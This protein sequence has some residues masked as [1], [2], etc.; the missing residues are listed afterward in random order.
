M[1]TSR[2]LNL[3]LNSAYGNI[4]NGNAL[5]DASVADTK[6]ATI[7]TAGKVSN[8][9]TTATDAN[10]N[11][12]IVARDGSGNFAATNVTASSLRSTAG[13]SVTVAALTG[14][15]V[16]T[17]YI[18][19]NTGTGITLNQLAA[20]G[21]VKTSAAGVLSTALIA[22]ADV[23]TNAAIA[24]TKLGTI[25]T[26]GKVSNSATTATNA[27]T[28]SA[29]VARDSSGN[30]IAGTLTLT[31][32][33]TTASGTLTL[34]AVNG[35]SATT[36]YVTINTTNGITLSQLA[37]A[38]LVHTNSSG[39]LSTSL[40]VDA[41]VASN[42]AIADTKLATISTSGKVSNTATTATSANTNSAIVARD[43]SGN[44]AANNITATTLSSVANASLSIAALNISSVSTTYVTVNTSSGITLNQLA[45]AGLVHTNASGVLSTS[46]L[47]NADVA[48]NAAIA[49]TKLGTISTSGKVSNSA[50]T[51]TN[52][53]TASAIVARDGSGNF[54][55]GTLTLTGVTTTTSGTLTLSAVNG[56]SATTNYVTINTTN[57]ITLPQLASAGLVHTNASGVL[58]TS[59]LVNADVATNAAIADTKLA[60]ISTSGKV[61]NS[62]TTAVSTNTA[63]AI[64]ARDG[65]GNFAAGNI[66]ATTLSSVANASLSIAALNVSSAST[67]YVTVNTASGITL[68][69]LAS[70]GL[71]HTNASGVL[72]TSLLVDADVASNAAIADTKLAT[73]S[74][75]GK[76]SNSATTASSSN[77]LNTIVARD[78]S[79]NTA[80]SEISANG[81]KSY[82]GSP[83]TFTALSGASAATMYISINTTDGITF[84]QHTTAGVLKTD[85][86]GIV[87]S[88]LLTNADVAAAAGIVDSKL[89][90]ISTAGKVSNSATTA[91][92]ANTASAIVARDANGD[93]TARNITTTG[94]VSFPSGGNTAL[95]TRY[96]EYSTTTGQVTGVNTHSNYTYHVTQ[97]GRVVTIT[98]SQLGGKT[99]TASSD[100]IINVPSQFRPTTQQYKQM[101]VISGSTVQTGRLSAS[102]TQISIQPTTNGGNWS[103]TSTS[104]GWHAT[105][106]SWV[107][108]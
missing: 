14:G 89:A 91:T 65:S 96:E 10:T 27:N 63:S 106:I 30:F 6:L 21:V 98:L 97:V 52:A 35:S 82:A 44:F 40:L 4:V 73:I 90:T 25:S 58:S 101:T 2:V 31:G 53:N 57:G 76:V 42:A 102:S 41:D 103:S 24:D 108:I 50:T 78:G 22:N 51:A 77:G 17:T 7:S 16:V 19:V 33:T 86:S 1:A 8:S 70:A 54:I 92:N 32:I 47:V 87:S 38:G 49:D 15:S 23:A 107:L 56:S 13:G 48:T 18:T 55:A 66:T 69:Q 68:N 12:A 5:V 34:S 67:T 59:L 94:G 88:S 104:S 43:G 83:L 105:S 74:T 84:P 79:G 11:S 81:L 61:S 20:A 93:F 26:S 62:A 46:L 45:S 36:N 95:L 72:S 99:F 29:I 9:A 80:L 37:S 3:A 39:V 28:A 71:V 75:S 64:V 60:T 100:A 85:S